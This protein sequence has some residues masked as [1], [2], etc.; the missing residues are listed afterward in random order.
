MDLYWLTAAE[1][2]CRRA[3]A[4]IYLCKMAANVVVLCNPLCFLV[5]KFGRTAAKPI[6]SMISG[7]ITVGPEGAWPT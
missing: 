3:A 1:T 5:N 4:T 2:S 7:R 6:K